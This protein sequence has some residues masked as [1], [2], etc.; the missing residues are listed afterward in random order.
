V[1]WNDLT[2]KY[3]SMASKPPAAKPVPTGRVPQI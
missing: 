2:G 1:R 3:S